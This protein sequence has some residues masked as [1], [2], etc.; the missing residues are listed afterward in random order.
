MGQK[1]LSE[2]ILVAYNDVFADIVNVLLFNGEKQIQPEELEDRGTK[3]FYKENGV[4]HEMERD[5]VKRWRKEEVRFAC[6]G[7]ENQ[8]AVDPDM[9]LRVIGY[10]GAA[11]RAQLSDEKQSRERY[12]V[13]TI[14]LYFGHDKKWDKPLHLLEK[15]TVPDGLDPYVSDYKVNLFQ[16]AWLSEEQVAMFQSD[17]K[18]VADYFVQK[19]KNNSYIPT[20]EEIK[21]VEAV[22]QLL[23]IMEHDD[24]FAETMYRENG[25]K[26]KNM[27]DVLDAAEQ[28]GEIRGEKRGELRGRAEGRAEAVSKIVTLLYGQGYLVKEIVRMTGET[29]KTVKD[30]LQL[31]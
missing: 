20:K 26:V 4:L 24:R 30:I 27:C 12:P 15:L 22:L 14:V 17:F 8:T 2:K 11:Y 13:I 19:R 29:E 16:V 5:V 23:S 1:D 6:I 28:R 31:L 10:D 18:I 3:A 25:R 9:T 7:I 21:H